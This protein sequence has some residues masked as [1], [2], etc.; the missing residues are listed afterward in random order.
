M[1]ITAATVG[2]QLRDQNLVRGKGCQRRV[3]AR[4]PPCPI[5]VVDVAH[6]MVG[7]ENSDFPQ[8]F[9]RTVRRNAEI[10]ISLRGLINRPRRLAVALDAL[11]RLDL[12]RQLEMVIKGY[13]VVA[14][15]IHAKE[16][17]LVAEGGVGERQIAVDLQRD[18]ADAVTTA[19]GHAIVLFR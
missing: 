14:R 18:A 17:Q 2:Q 1:E 15:F 4:A 6:R 5:G 16:L 7:I 12:R 8:P 11:N 3:A 9:G 13:R 19:C 10:E